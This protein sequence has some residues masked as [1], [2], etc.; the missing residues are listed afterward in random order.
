MR[1][2][3]RDALP[4]VKIQLSQ[5]T[6]HFATIRDCVETDY[7]ELIGLSPILYAVSIGR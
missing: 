2:N 3:E 1:E 7:F 5:L 4:R 6:M